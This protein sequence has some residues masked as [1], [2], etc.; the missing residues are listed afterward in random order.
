[1]LRPESNFENIHDLMSY[2]PIDYY[3]LFQKSIAENSDTNEENSAETSS[4]KA[5][6]R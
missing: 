3:I 4:D 1:M 2:L 6:T 5:K